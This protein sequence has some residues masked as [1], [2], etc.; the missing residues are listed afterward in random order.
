MIRNT[1]KPC[2]NQDDT[3]DIAMLNF[4]GGYFVLLL[5]KD[6]SHSDSF[7]LTC[8]PSSGTWF[9]LLLVRSPPQKTIKNIQPWFVPAIFEGT[10]NCHVFGSPGLGAPGT[11]TMGV[12]ASEL[13][14][15]PTELM[16]CPVY[17][18]LFWGHAVVALAPLLVTLW[19]IW[20]GVPWGLGRVTLGSLDPWIESCLEI[21]T[22]AE[23]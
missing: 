10:W 22:F 18:L 21:R 19:S 2:F 11:Q 6:V 8:S 9:G 7:V 3:A 17:A 16:I 1:L 14:F 20:P 12:S 15:P 23:R 13:T 5:P 4:N